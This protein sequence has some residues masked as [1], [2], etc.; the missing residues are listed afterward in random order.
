MGT[1]PAVVSSDP[2]SVAVRSVLIMADG[3]FADFEEVVHPEARDRENKI[4]PPS[5]RVAGPACFYSTALWLRAAFAG[6]HYDIHHAI[7]DGD[8]VAVNSTMNGRHMAP[9]VMYT[10]EGEIDT[11]FPPTG[12]TFATTQS[13]WFRVA[14]GKVIEHWANRDDMGHALQLGWIP[15]TPVYLARM[16]RAKAKAKRAAR[17]GA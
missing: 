14:D 15:P 3:E 1:N 12:R 9:W 4:Q 7:A 2:V 5:S 17:A 8:L 11:V 16:A 13:H 6:L 10:A